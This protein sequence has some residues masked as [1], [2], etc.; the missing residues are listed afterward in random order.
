M[1]PPIVCVQF[2]VDDGAAHLMTKRGEFAHESGTLSPPTANTFSSLLASWINGGATLVGHNVAYD[3]ACFVAQDQALAPLVFRAY[4]E[5]RITDTMWRQRLSDLGRGKYRGFFRGPVW[6]PLQ[7]DLGSVARRHDF[8]VDKEEPWRMHY[9][10]LDEIPL[11][12]WPDFFARVSDVRKGAKPG[13]EVSLCGQDAIRYALG[14]PLATRAAFVGQARE[15]SADLLVDEFCQ[16]RRFWALHLS[17][18]W[19]IRTSL[20]GV[21]S[22]EKGARERYD[23]LGAI[24]LDAGLVRHKSKRDATLVRDTKAAKERIERAYAEIGLPVRR[25]AKDGTCLDSDSCLSSGDPLLESYSEF[26]SMAKVISNDVE[27]LRRGTVSP[28]STS[29]GLA[30]TGRTTSSSPNIQNPRRLPGVRE[31]FVP[32]GFVG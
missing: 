13:A 17:S 21:L 27:M 23:H 22:L 4:R 19:G 12:G 32:M 7:Y 24:L 2:A 31:A 25:T 18:V 8:L 30:E 9:A 29:W 5:S 16:A 10:L 11:K 20:R 6:V 28:I 26:S 14:D 1:A 15:Y 3:L